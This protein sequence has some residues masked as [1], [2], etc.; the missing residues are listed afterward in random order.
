[1]SKNFISKLLACMFV[2]FNL[3]K[4]RELVLYLLMNTPWPSVYIFLNFQ[5]LPVPCLKSSNPFSF[6]LA[7]KI[8]VLDAY[9]EETHL[10]FE[11]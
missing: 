10:E 3:E 5:L 11:C 9:I 8:H 2:M 6:Q 4:F 7:L 1:M